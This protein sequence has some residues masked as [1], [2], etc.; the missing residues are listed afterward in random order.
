V[1]ASA[2]LLETGAGRGDGLL[3]WVG[4]SPTAKAAVNEVV[5]L[6]VKLTREEGKNN[7]AKI[8][9]AGLCGEPFTFDTLVAVTGSEVFE[10]F[11]SP[12]RPLN[13]QSVEAVAPPQSKRER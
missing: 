7:T 12:A 9:E 5:K 8:L 1:T 6:S 10:L 2:E 3:L 13:H 4:A 11:R